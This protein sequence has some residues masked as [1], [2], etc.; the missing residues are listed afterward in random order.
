MKVRGLLNGNSSRFIVRIVVGNDSGA[1]ERSPVE[2]GR[3]V[4]RFAVESYEVPG[5]NPVDPIE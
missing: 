3:S 4:V 2:I 5:S 1:E